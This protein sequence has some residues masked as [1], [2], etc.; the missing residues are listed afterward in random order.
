MAGILDWLSDVF[1]GSSAASAP[2]AAAQPQ[3]P[4]G[5]TMGWPQGQ[6]PTPP[7]PQPSAAPGGIV[8][9]DGSSPIPG[10]AGGGAGPVPS[11][12]D[13]AP[14]AVPMPQPRPAAADA[15]TPGGSLDMDL[16][17]ARAQAAGGAPMSLAPPQPQGQPGP[18]SPSQS[19][20]QALLQRAFGVPQD[21][22][23]QLSA[24]LGAGLTAAAN[25]WNKPGLAAFAGG[26]G[27]ALTGGVNQ[28]NT[29]SKD[30]SS[31]LDAA[32]KSKQQ[33]DEAGYKQNYLKYL[34][35]QLQANQAKAAAANN[36]TNKNDTPTQLYLNAQRL[37]QNDPEVRDASKAL[38]A[39]R[40]DGNVDAIAQA[41][42]NLQKITQTKQQQHYQAL[43][44]NPQQAAAI[45]GQAGNSSQTAITGL[46]P[47]SIKKLQPGQYYVN[48]SDGQVYQY[49]GASN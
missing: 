22:G 19:V 39:A 17:N 33:N 42:A 40:Q 32:I 41:Q 37:V 35:A 20:G 44:I 30:A 12:S 34:A 47:T 14:S 2:A 10:T 26:A 24:S 45:G 38:T 48:P 7:A 5:V 49:K 36:A 16:L 3:L 23:R 11:V 31:Y 46:T 13:L 27:G 43:G 29:E 15:A 4:T 8:A 18:G 28:A 6:Q 21:Q 9:A 25:N 1:G